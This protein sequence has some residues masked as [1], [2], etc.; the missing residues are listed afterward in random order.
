MRLLFALLL[1][2]MGQAA[3]VQQA[4]LGVFASEQGCEITKTATSFPASTRQVFLRLLV[5]Q[6]RPGDTLAVEW[7][8]PS[9]NIAASAP[10]EEL[11]PARTLC[12]LT[13][14]PVGGF[15]PARSPGQWS[16][17]VTAGGKVLVSRPFQ[18]TAETDRGAPQILRVAT[19][20][21]SE[22]ETE[23]VIEGDGFNSESIVHVAQYTPS[24]GWSYIAHL[25]PLSLEPN[26]MTARVGTLKPAE[27][28]VFVKNAEKLSAPARFLITTGGYRLPMPAGTA[29]HLSQPPY[30]MYSHWGSTLHAYDIAPRGNACVVAMKAGTAFTFDLGLGQTPH[31]RIFGNYITVQHDDGEFSHYAHLRSGAFR[32]QHGERVEQGQA[33]AIAGNSG[34]SFG[35]HVHVQVTKSFAISS[36]SI[37]FTLEDLAPADHNGYRGPIMSANR[38]AYGDC[39]GGRPPS[40][41]FISTTSTRPA[42]PAVSPTWTGSVPLAGWWTELTAVPDG[43]KALDIRLD[44]DAG[45]HDLDLHLVS[46]S[47]KHYGSYGDRSGYNAPAINQESFH[48]ENPEPGTWRVSVQGMSSGGEAMDFRVYRS[49]GGTLPSAWGG[50]RRR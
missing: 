25:F 13:Q 29:W 36:Q 16:V 2:S 23:L 40:P 39:N 28:V 20:E 42:A 30:G 41:A 5:S 12:I 21:R 38:S 26:R 1:G 48:I 27:Y 45:N 7:L 4:H 11:P 46:P 37:P 3:Q 19:R 50:V 6:I 31:R 49:L 15:A 35:A 24:G 8:D 18:I 47:G 22:Q 34:Y 33:L 9:G 44:W 32:V 10:Y 14:L 43:S 17:R